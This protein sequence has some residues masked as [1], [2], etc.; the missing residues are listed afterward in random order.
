M[1]QCSQS[2]YDVIVIGAGHAGCEAA[3]AAARMGQQVLLLTLNMD[4]VALMPCNPSIGGPAKANLVREI[5]ALGGEMGKNID[6]TLMQMRMLN[7][8]KG[9]AVQALRAQADRKLYQR[10]MKEVLETT[11]RLYLKE[12]LVEDLVTDNQQ[13]IG[14]VVRNQ[15]IAAKTVILATG[16]YLR[17]KIFL[18][19]TVYTSGPQGQ[20]SAEA[21]GHNLEKLFPLARFKTGTPPRVNLR[22]LDYDQMTI[23]PGNE[24]FRGFSFET[25]GI[26]V[27]Q[28]P[29]WL[30]YTNR[31]THQI[32]IDNLD[33]SA[34][35][36]GAIVGVGPRYCP[37]IESKVVQFPKRE[38]HQVFVEPEGWNTSEGYLSG[39]STSLPADVQQ[40]LLQTIP[41][42]AQVEMM[43]PGYAIEYDCLDPLMLNSFLEIKEY[44]GLFA[45]GQINGTSGY[46]EAAAQGLLAGINAALYC[47]EEPLISLDRSQAYLGVLVDDLVLKGTNEPYRM[48]TSRAEYRLLLRLDNAD[49]RLT[50]IAHELGLISDQRFLEFKT[51]WNSI[52]AEVARLET[53][54]IPSTSD[55]NDL[56]ADLGSS[57]LRHGV[58]LSE[59]LKRPEIM[60]TDLAKF[61]SLPKLP[62]DV[63]EGVEI[64]VK[65]QGYLKKQERAIER[66]RRIE[67]KRLPKLDFLHVRGLSREAAEKLN[68]SQPLTLGQASRISGVSPADISVLMIYLQQ[69]SGNDLNG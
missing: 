6:A 25:K 67:G 21:L 52:E 4:N 31:E 68:T 30:T 57:P 59:L 26:E 43:R 58:S 36:S 63:A 35:Y 54:Q 27:E 9:P 15:S 46:E 23:Q 33:K 61:Q 60:Y 44:D 50:P 29:C 42:L 16:T 22:S 56:L 38:G 32:I 69:M 10:R 18:G 2:D 41:G 28:T 17:A 45:A 24:F 49:M 51:K 47:R 37:S 39:L 14:V 19:D 62:R 8:R 40:K 11:P 53:V 5:D 12:G 20:H 48:M 3:L 66:F 55:T 65:Y 13:V 1:F 64:T 34:M 7:T